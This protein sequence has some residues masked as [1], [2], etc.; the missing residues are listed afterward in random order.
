MFNFSITDASDVLLL[1]RAIVQ[2][3]GGNNPDGIFAPLGLGQ[4]DNAVYSSIN[5]T[6]NRLG[7]AALVSPDRC[8]LLF[9]GVSVHGTGRDLAYSYALPPNPEPGFGENVVLKNLAANSFRDVFVQVIPLG[10][11]ICVC[12]Y[13]AGAACALFIGSSLAALRPDLAVRAVG[14]NSPRPAIRDYARRARAVQWFRWHNDSDPIG[15]L[16]LHF[17]ESGA[18]FALTDA[19]AAGRCELYEQMGR[20][21]RVSPAGALTVLPSMAPPILNAGPVTSL[22]GWATGTLEQP[23]LEHSL[24]EFVRRLELYT[25][26]NAPGTST[27]LIIGGGQPYSDEADGY[28]PAILPPAQVPQNAIAGRHTRDLE[29]E[30]AAIVPEALL[31]SLAYLKGGQRN[32][33]YARS[34]KGTH[35]LMYR[36]SVVCVEKGKRLARRHASSLNSLVAR[37]NETEAP[38]EREVVG[39]FAAE[40]GIDLG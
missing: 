2:L 1:A 9:D 36:G 18:A 25:Q 40:T 4:I 19:I 5:P 32:P 27:A 12:G 37:C 14:I 24:P 29:G 15:R 22:F 30:A 17:E 11:R 13:S 10:A 20:G 7:A 35:Y 6:R 8:V 3:R 21:F 23:V 38:D 16:P 26:A 28:A 31:G 39:T 34:I 33:Y